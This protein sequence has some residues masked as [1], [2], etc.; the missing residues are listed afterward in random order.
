M[1]WLDILKKFEHHSTMK[2]PY[3]AIDWNL[4]ITPLGQHDDLGDAD[5]AAEKIMKN[6]VLYIASR[7]SLVH[8]SNELEKVFFEKSGFAP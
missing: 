8:L 3:Y 7:E 1:I 4:D 5:D 6:E 2:Q